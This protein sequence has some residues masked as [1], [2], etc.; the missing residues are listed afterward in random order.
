MVA[1]C[2]GP[3]GAEGAEGADGAARYSLLQRT[4]ERDLLPMAEHFGLSVLAWAPI[5]RGVGPALEV[6]DVLQVLS[7]DP[8]APADLR[9]KAI[10]YAG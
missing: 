10:A 9:D 2:R 4:P 3:G 8:G 1:A 6:R 7:G 5:G